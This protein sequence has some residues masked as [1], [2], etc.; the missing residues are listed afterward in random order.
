MAE[1]DPRVHTASE[2]HKRPAPKPMPKKAR[3]EV[4]KNAPVAVSG[5]ESGPVAEGAAPEPT[6]EQAADAAAAER[7][8]S[9]APVSERPAEQ[10]DEKPEKPD[11]SAKPKKKRRWGLRIA[12]S[13]V[14]LLVV[15]MLVF[16]GFTAVNRWMTHDDAADFQGTWYVRGTSVPVTISNSEISFNASTAY[17]YE[18]DPEAKTIAFRLG[19]MEGQG[20]YWFSDDRQTLVITD[21]NGFTKWSTL[22]DDVKYMVSCWFGNSD[23]PASEGSTV[24]GRSIDLSAE[25]GV[26]VGA[27]SGESASGSEGGAGEAGAQDAQDG[28]AAGEEGAGDG[29]QRKREEFDDLSISDVIVHEGEDESGEGEGEEGDL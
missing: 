18:I 24:L 6:P 3:K 4:R 9:S 17:A 12:V 8:G 10:P 22:E 5:V 20:R 29:S 19:N 27:G 28:N 21:G 14:L 7:Q 1:D 2:V 23:L 15:A 16:A 11:A 26:G 13:V 25:V